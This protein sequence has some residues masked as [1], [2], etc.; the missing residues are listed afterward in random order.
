MVRQGKYKYVTTRGLAPM[1]FDLEADP[2]E[3]RDLAGTPALAPIEAELRSRA[4]Q[5]WDPERVHSEI[6]ASQ[7]RRRFLA[8]VAA[9]SGRYPNWAFQPYVNESKR[10]IRGAG[11]A[12][13]TAVKRRARLPFVAPARPDRTEKSCM[14]AL[15]RTDW[16]TTSRSN[17]SIAVHR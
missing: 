10:Y 1:L 16:R 2:H 3:L 9:K 15:Q 12:G 14:R 6:L 4:M 17:D 7:K 11:G 8:E 13:P 5:G